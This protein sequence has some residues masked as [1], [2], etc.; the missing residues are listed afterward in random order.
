MES[1]SVV[2]AG[3]G[4]GSGEWEHDDETG[5]LVQILRADDTIETGLW[6]PGPVAGVPIDLQLVADETIY[7]VSGSGT[8]EV[9][10]EPP[11]DLRPGVM[12]SIRKGARTRW[13]VDEAFEEFWVY[14]KG[15]VAAP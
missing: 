8:L 11:I 1:E 2:F 4:T 13:V 12:V 5:G 10:G 3:T 15:A 6:R 9:D 7:V 14:A